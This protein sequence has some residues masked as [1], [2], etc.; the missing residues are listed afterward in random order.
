MHTGH[1]LNNLSVVVV[2]GPVEMWKCGFEPEKQRVGAPWDSCEKSR[3]WMWT[4]GPFST[5][6]LT[7]RERDPK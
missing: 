6:D 7:D 4:E 3:K 1:V 2:V 5:S